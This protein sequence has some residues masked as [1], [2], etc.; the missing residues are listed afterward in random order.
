METY[1]ISGVEIFSAGT[2]NG[3]KYTT[4]DLNK[5][6]SAF[7]ETN[8]GVRPFLKLG[9]DDD[10]KILQKDGLPAAGW[11]DRV[12]V[13]GEK[14][15]ADFT[16]IP[17]KIYD[18]IKSKAYRKV[19]CE[20]FYNISINDKKYQY[21]LGAVALLG[22][23]T[24]GVMN[25]KDI[26]SMYKAI[27]KDQ[28]LRVYLNEA[29]ELKIKNSSDGSER[30]E[31]KM[32]KTENEIKLE[33]DLKLKTD[34]IEAEKEKAK[35]YAIDLKAKEDEIEK[36]QK[37]KADAEKI[38][39]DLSLQAEK[40]KLEKFVT[41][42]QSEKLCSLSMKPYIEELLGP[43]KKEYS[44]NINEKETKHS[45]ESLLKE[46]LLLFKE[47]SKVNFEES[48][49]DGDKKSYAKSDEE[50]HKKAEEYAKENNVSYG[51]ALKEVIK[52]KNSK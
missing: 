5:M 9:H 41:E 6:V 46:A 39:A 15:M 27:G 22:A 47:A 7:N 23:D 11:V 26:L 40:S 1:K 50:A 3:D 38:Q 34:E 52:S 49:E 18:L 36:L 20:I 12:Y 33:F 48:S 24:P 37:F 21:L 32:S 19:S 17:K 4:D 45:K 51:A 16:D 2:W 31:Q 14:L 43:E 25:L 28:E 29:L 10:Q 13:V 30:K 8:V 35:Q 42:L 44:L